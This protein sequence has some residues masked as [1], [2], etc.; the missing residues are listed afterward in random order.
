[1]PPSNFVAERKKKP[2]R[3]KVMPLFLPIS[4]D[5]RDGAFWAERLEVM[6]TL[7]ENRHRY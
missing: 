2:Y 5:A 4:S 1:M 3:R 7:A 6:L